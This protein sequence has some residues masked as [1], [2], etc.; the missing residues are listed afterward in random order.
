MNPRDDSQIVNDDNATTNSQDLQDSPQD[1]EKMKPESVTMDMPEVKDIPGQEHVHAAPP[2]ELADTTISS[3]DE[4]GEG[5]LDELED[6]DMI[7]DDETENDEDEDDLN[8]DDT[9]DA[10]ANVSQEEKD[11][12]DDAG[13]AIPDDEQL[14]RSALDNVDDDGEPLNEGSSAN[15]ISGSDLDAPG[16]E[17]DD[18]NEDIGEEDEENNTYSLG[19]ENEQEGRGD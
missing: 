5:V 7:D 19:G 15:A 11:I 10:D 6:D 9:A 16:T 18:A 8:D 13:S 17:D 14:R 2:G 1:E 3:A 12:L 4:E